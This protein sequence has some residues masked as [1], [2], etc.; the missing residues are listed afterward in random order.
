M[1]VKGGSKWYAYVNDAYKDGYNNAAG[2]LNLI[3][4]A[5]GDRVEFYFAGGIA[6]AND[7][8]AVKAAATAAVKTVASITAMPTDWTLQLNGARDQ[9][10]TRAFFEEGL[11]CPSS[12]HYV[13]WTDEDGNVWGGVPLWLLVAMVDDDPDAGPDH[14]NF[15][16]DLAAQGYEVNVVAGDNW[17]ATLDSSAIAR[18][19]GY[20]V[21]NSL[22]GQPL[23]MLTQSGKPCWPL[24]LKGSAV[25][26]GQQVGNI[27]RIE[28]SDLPE[29]PAGWNLQLVG[30]V[31]YTVTQSEFD[32]GLACPG[33]GHLVEWTD[34]D[35]NVWSGV[36]LY[37]LLGA[38]DDNETAAHWSFN[39]DVAAAGYSV[40]VTASDNFSRTFSSAKVA[41]NDDYIVANQMNG[42]ALADSWPLRLVGPGVTKADGSLG[43]SAVGKI[44]RIEI[45]ELQTPPAATGS[46]NL[47]LK[48]K[49][50]D[51]MSQEE[52]EAALACPDGQHNVEWTDMDGNVWSGMPLWF[53][54]GWVDDTVPH[55]FNANQ[56]V[57]G[58]KVLV[59]AGDGYTKEF[60]SADVAWSSNYIVANR[61]NGQ[62]LDETWPL[63]LVGAGVTRPDG[64]LGGLSVGEIA[65][66]ELTEFQTVL[67]VPQ[68][69]I[70]K[71]AQDGTTVLQET[72]VD[73]LWMQQNL[74]VVGDGA[75]V[76]KYEAVTNDP[77]D[78]WDAAETYPG[79]FKIENAV[80]G[81]R[82][83]D[84]CELVGGMGS[85]TE[86]VFV[87]SDGYE[88]ILPY[89]A[90]YTNPAVQARQG[91]AIMA[92]YA[93]GEYVPY[94][95]DGIRL[96]FAPDGDHVYGQWD[97]H[98][99]LAENYW[100]YYWSGGVQ[101]AS[102]AGLSNKNVT[103]IRI[104]STPETDWTLELDGT[105]IGGLDYEVSKTYFEQALVCQFG[106][107]HQASY[108]DAK[109]RV[110]S[111]M[112]L[113]FLAGFVDDAD[114]HSSNS[115]NDV[116]ATTGYRVVI[117][118]SDGSVVT[119]G[120]QDIARSGDYIVAN[121][122]NGAH[123]A[124]TDDS[125]PLRLVG[126]AVGGS[127]SIKGIVR[128]ELLPAPVITATAEADG[129]ISPSGEVSV[130][131]GMDQAFTIAA[132][133]G[134][135]I[136]D[137]AVDGVSQGPIEA[138]TFVNV[139]GDGT[140]AASFAADLVAPTAEFSAEPTGG[141]APLTVAF[142]DLSTGSAPLTYAWDFD[143]D[144]SV[145]STSPNPSYTFAAAGTYTVSLS[146]SNA[147]GTDSEEKTD[148]IAVTP[149]PAA[150]IRVISPNG[151][152]WFR[153]GYL[154][155]IRWTSR[156]VTGGV[157]IEV[158]RD[159]GAT[160]ET[161]SA[162]TN[163]DGWYTWR[164][165][166]PST[167][168]ARIRVTSLST[169]VSDTSN[170]SFAIYGAPT[171]SIRVISPNGGQW[172]SVGSLK[173][174]TWTSSNVTGRVMIQVSRDGG[175]TWSTISASTYND[176][177][178]TWR[179]TGPAT[180]RARIRVVSLSTGASDT[181][182][183]SFAIR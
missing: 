101:Y 60:A 150:S 4:L 122:L 3:E 129:A 49:I 14:F 155:A 125:W 85:G 25:F 149:A 105:D 91:D 66:I 73:Y 154:K 53:L 119:M 71:Y 52:F 77:A 126:P 102:C 32:A 6:D 157:R 55:D 65:E 83:R 2:A 56:A 113:W 98:E 108:I 183:Y 70:V 16:D 120:S 58:Y 40:I 182:N 1:Y 156:N 78:I 151:G 44:A 5:D 17:T 72:T 130:P 12:G 80:M 104:Y 124:D 86:I 148:Y 9:A 136:L 137:V 47:A 19:G 114:Q 21:A 50:T 143:N 159:R 107:E 169:G 7:L 177:R 29:P 99:T 173:T 67:P 94:Y 93:D 23:P 28:L 146:V 144:G 167:Y 160:W 51:V 64:T 171:A 89:S 30:E 36:P 172:W 74:D 62:P 75:T 121:S 34:I 22:N 27:V 18:N 26:G 153:V 109:G 138:Y 88:T 112:P 111:G 115:F 163:N 176:G 87:A 165:T 180:Y 178:Y 162:S 117:T 103:T 164:V 81:T 100:H 15:N 140:I 54:A 133:D 132:D 11:A 37:V 170:Y 106:A 110:W 174:I 84:L 142:T 79:G 118:A 20:I 135:H 63:R 97:M 39:D 45:P 139:I 8:D 166:G 31:G 179:V 35:G 147:A 141:V 145:D 181:S 10:V 48:G 38:V 59:K 33:S 161:I 69:H 24:Y 68:L 175:A 61:V 158:S 134:Y 168:S 95:G 57:A 43:G 92:W 42:Q 46:W 90:I 116:L 76:Y 128:I 96:F 13:E 127:L 41:R 123:L 82:V 131:Y 152:Q